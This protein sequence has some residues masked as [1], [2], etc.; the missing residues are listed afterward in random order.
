MKISELVKLHGLPV[1]IRHLL[2]ETPGWYEV[3]APSRD[4]SSYPAFDDTGRVTS[5]CIEGENWELYVAPKPKKK[6]DAYV[7]MVDGVWSIQFCDS[8][9]LPKLPQKHHLT[10]MPYVRVPQFDCEVDT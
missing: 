4:T 8:G 6:F 3:V 10:T 9:Y 1:K 5:A 7:V 2:W